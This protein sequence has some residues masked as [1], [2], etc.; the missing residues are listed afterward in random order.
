MCIC[1]TPWVMI[2][3]LVQRRAARVNWPV[4]SWYMHGHTHGMRLRHKSAGHRRVNPPASI[5][6]EAKAPKQ[7]KMGSW[8]PASSSA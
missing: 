2:E 4:R 1:S 6:A 7:R 8:P 5:G 3:A